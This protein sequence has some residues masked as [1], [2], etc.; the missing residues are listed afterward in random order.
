MARILDLVFDKLDE[1]ILISEKSH[2]ACV[3]QP[4]S[5]CI[6]SDNTLTVQERA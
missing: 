4:D 6:S 2:S 3:D 5:I 1:M